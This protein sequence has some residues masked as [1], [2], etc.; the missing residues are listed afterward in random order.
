MLFLRLQ[1]FQTGLHGGNIPAERF[2]ACILYMLKFLQKQSIF[3][4]Q[5]LQFL[6]QLCKSNSQF[7]AADDT[8]KRQ[9]LFL[10]YKCGTL[11]GF[12]LDLLS[13]TGVTLQFRPPYPVSKE[14]WAYI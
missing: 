14:Y 1:L 7:P 13:Q 8:E 3:S 11:S 5:F 2:R 6:R 10:S 12:F 4:A 9:F